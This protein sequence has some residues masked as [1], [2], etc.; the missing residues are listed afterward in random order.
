M[1]F[2]LLYILKMHYFPFLPR[3]YLSLGDV[4]LFSRKH[5]L[6]KE[7]IKYGAYYSNVLYYI[8]IEMISIC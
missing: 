8:A 5:S 3:G 2:Y 6:W 1:K 7:K 4:K